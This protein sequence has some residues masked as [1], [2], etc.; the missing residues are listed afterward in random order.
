MQ[1]TGRTILNYTFRFIISILSHI[2]SE[3]VHAFAKQSYKVCIARC[4]SY[5]H[6]IYINIQG[7]NVK[8]DEFQAFIDRIN[9]K[10]PINVICLQEC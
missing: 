5:I 9:V 1:S 7:V 8:F 2:T 3:I 10:N 4:S 6:N